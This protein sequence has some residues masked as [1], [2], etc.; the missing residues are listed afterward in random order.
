MTCRSPSPVVM[1][2]PS[3]Q[4]TALPT[5][6]GKTHRWPAVN[7]PLTQSLPLIGPRHGACYS[8]LRRVNISKLHQQL[9]ISIHL[10]CSCTVQLFPGWRRI[11]IWAFISTVACPGKTTLIMCTPAACVRKIGILA[12]RRLHHKIRP[13]AL[14]RI[15]HQSNPTMAQICLLH[16]ERGKYQQV[17]QT[18]RTVLPLAPDCLT[19][20]TTV[21]WLAHIG[22]VFQDPVELAP[23][24]PY[25]TE[26]LPPFSSHCGYNSR[27]TLY[28]VPAVKKVIHTH[29]FLSTVFH[30]TEQF[31]IKHPEQCITPQV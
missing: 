15:F 22:V 4:M 2:V 25:L 17:G 1:S 21:I 30:P 20:I 14:R 8:A 19:S 16:V 11:N 18:S 24:P 13:T 5:L 7:F 27:K 12:L 29:V 28:P 23:A 10:M 6:P 3:L 31:A 9:R 26:L